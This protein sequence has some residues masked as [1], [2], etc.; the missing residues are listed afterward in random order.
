MRKANTTT[1][2]A[3]KNQTRRVGSAGGESYIKRARRAAAGLDDEDDTETCLSWKRKLGRQPDGQ[4]GPRN[5]LGTSPTVVGKPSASSIT[6]FPDECPSS[7]GISNMH[8]H[9]SS[10]PDAGMRFP[11]F[12]TVPS[13]SETVASSREDTEADSVWTPEQP[14]GGR[15][16]TEGRCTASSGLPGLGADL[17]GCADVNMDLAHDVPGSLPPPPLLPHE[18][19][20]GDVNGSLVIDCGV[21]LNLPDTRGSAMHSSGRL[22]DVLVDGPADDSSDPEVPSAVVVSRSSCPRKRPLA[23]EEAPSNR[24]NKGKARADAFVLV[25]EGTSKEGIDDTLPSSSRATA[26]AA[27]EAPPTQPHR[28]KGI[29]AKAK[30]TPRNSGASENVRAQK[31]TPRRVSKAMS[32]DTSDDETSD[33]DLVAQGLRVRTVLARPR[34][35]GTWRVVEPPSRSV[36]STKRSPAPSSR[37]RVWAGCKEELF[38]ALPALAKNNGGVAW[39]CL[40]CPT[41]IF[42]GA[43]SDLGLGWW[44]DDTW[45]CR[46][47]TFSILMQEAEA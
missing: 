44:E 17:S 8:L 39:E 33:H 18:L 6:T 41:L 19:S 11:L 27:L 28:A 3:L 30:A 26:V 42:S 9:S 35:K 38:A 20:R 16:R 32:S 37:P 14:S 15:V 13:P 40:E 12:R 47:I 23:T 34:T 7:S 29:N 4:S 10:G 31:A 2:I 46:K 5:S 1:L 43:R 45:E 25:D 24:K 21:S 22:P 36:Y